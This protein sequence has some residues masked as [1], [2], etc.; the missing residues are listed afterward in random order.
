M[1]VLAN[2]T[3]VAIA[4]RALLIEGPPGSGKS[5]LALALIDRGAILVGDDAIRVTR[6]GSTLIAAPPPNTAGFI[7][8]RNVGLVELP[9][10]KGP[11]ALILRLDSKA[12]RFPMETVT[13]A[14]E[15]I[16]VPVLPFAAGDAVQALRAEYA[17]ASHGLPLPKS[18]QKA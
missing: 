18:V 3:G 15:G 12:P 2:V 11:V 1:T 4:G 5:S 16:E 10:A 8:L 9:V 6:E 17:L 13:R 7:E 14:V